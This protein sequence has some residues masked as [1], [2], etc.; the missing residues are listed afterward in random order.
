[1][2]GSIKLFRQ[3][4][5]WGWYQDVNVKS[6]F[7]E[8]L[9][10]ARY[11]DGDWQD[12]HMKRGQLV[13]SLARLSESTGL[14]VHQVR[15][16]LEKLEST[17]EIKRQVT[18]R[19][20][21]ITV[22]N[23]DKWQTNDG[24]EWQANDNQTANECQSNGNQVSNDSQA[25]DKQMSTFNKEN[26]EIKNNISTSSSSS[27]SRES[28]K[29]WMAELERTETE[30]FSTICLGLK[31]NNETYF[32]FLEGFKGECKLQDKIHL[33]W[34]DT[35]EH[36]IRWCRCEMDRRAKNNGKAIGRNAD[37]GEFEPKAN[38]DYTAS[39]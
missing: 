24:E 18:N 14:S 10:I 38:T 23:Y 3:F 4:R 22:C 17:G 34:S 27:I 36:F 9:L 11:S 29:K 25:D 12:I 7:I 5:E 8:L 21:L 39:F 15:T 13:V 20:S 6:L 2:A 33:S 32:E 1:M 35:R 16:A 30:S 31:I 37:R 28:E 26:K 19:F